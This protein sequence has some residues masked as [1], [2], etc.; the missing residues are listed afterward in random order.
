MSRR[1]GERRSPRT[2]SA[3]R[4]Q[5]GVVGAVL[6]VAIVVIGT[7]GIVTFGGQALG[8]TEDQMQVRNAENAMT[9]MD[10]KF[11]EVALG[12]SRAKTVQLPPGAQ[13]QEMTVEDGG[14]IRV[15]VYNRTTGDLRDEVLNE[16]LGKVVYERSGTTV[17][18]QGGGVWRGEGNGSSM[19][20]PPE[21]HYRGQTL[22]LPVVSVS[23]EGQSLSGRTT[24]EK[25]GTT[26]R[27]W[28]NPDA[29][30]NFTN[31]LQ[32]GRVV[33]TI[34]SDYY[35]AWGDFFQTRTSGSPSYDHDNE[36]VSVELVVER[37]EVDTVESAVVAGGGTDLDL[38]QNAEADSYNSSEGDYSA[39]QGENS[40][41]VVTGDL[42]MGNNANISG[43]AVVEGEVDMSNNAV[44]DGNLSYGASLTQANNAEIRGWD[45]PNATVSEP[46]PVDWVIAAKGND[47]ESA[48]NN[49]AEDDIDD[50]SDTLSCTGTCEIEPGDYY[51]SSIDSDSTTLYLNNTG[52]N[53]TI[54][55]DGDMDFDGEIIAN[56]TTGRVNFY[57]NGDLDLE[58]G[59]TVTVPGQRSPKLWFYLNP[60]SSATLNQ[61]VNVT[62]VIYGPGDAN[63]D[64]ADIDTSAG[65]SQ[66]YGALVGSV[67]QIDETTDV[68]YDEAL[69]D[70][71]AVT[72]DQQEYIPVVT[73]LHVTI[74]RVEV[75]S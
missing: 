34:G 70:T 25:N 42:D 20:S 33:V 8:D 15:R 17:A 45:A 66:V 44:I 75:D 43:D 60:G 49:S 21:F 23:G 59:T 58:Q 30:D 51:L 38:L 67:N 11:A 56:G 32:D 40:S 63:N 53:I 54:Y 19:V 57:L 36:T 48:N 7:I 74:N 22:T 46:D 5:S 16:T 24:I 37:E 65:D 13:G 2:L 4:G 31:P 52:G 71:R 27:L 9:Q 47:T 39:T 6:L 41:I 61:G 73:F 62:G 10:A 3:D 35:Q 50:A 18:Y 29:N 26:E 55:V 28:P 69:R 64:G 68:H 72:A 14:W 12:E 1:S